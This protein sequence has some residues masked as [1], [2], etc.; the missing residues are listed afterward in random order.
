M[1]DDQVE[2]MVDDY[3]FNQNWENSQKMVDALLKDSLYDRLQQ[4]IDNELDIIQE[5][6]L[7]EQFMKQLEGK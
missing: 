7:V 3:S 4:Y 2:K 6:Q 1:I 5:Y